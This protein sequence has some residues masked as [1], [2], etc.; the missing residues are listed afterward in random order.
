MLI[1]L[2]KPIFTSDKLKIAHNAKFDI[3]MLAN[4]GVDVKGPLA[5]TMLSAWILSPDQRGYGLDDCCLKFLNYEKIKLILLLDDKGSIV[6]AELSAL[7]EYACEDADLTLRL[8]KHLNKLVKEAKLEKPYSEIDTPL[9]PVLAK[10]EQDGIYIDKK[11]L[12][13]FSVELGEK[14]AE[15]QKKI[16]DIAGEEFNINSPKQFK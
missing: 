12:E 4:I 11:M 8:Y 5:D 9:V 2:L 13:D 14:A 6:H 7:T 16:Y 15:L 3:Q 1:E 10:M